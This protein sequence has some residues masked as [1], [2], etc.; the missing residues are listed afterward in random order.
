MRKVG[1]EEYSEDDLE[2]WQQQKSVS[3]EYLE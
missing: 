2:A 3:L 1:E